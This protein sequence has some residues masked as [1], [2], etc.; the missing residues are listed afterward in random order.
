MN[1]TPLD[2]AREIAQEC[3]SRAPV[4]VLGSGAS[5]PYG[6]PSMADLRKRLLQTTLP[7]ELH[8]ADNAAW[9]TF[10]TKLDEKD[11]E[12]ALNDVSLPNGLAR[13]VA[14]TTWDCIAPRDLCLLRRLVQDRSALVLTRLYRHLFASTHRTVHVVTPNYDR[15]AEYAADAGG[16][17]QY[18]GFSQGLLRSRAQEPALCNRCSRNSPRTVYIWKV[19]GSIDWFYN[20]E[21]SVVALPIADNRPQSLQPVIVTPGNEKYRI[22]HDEPFRSVIQGADGAMGAARGFLCIGYGFNDPHLQPRLADRLRDPSVP[23]VLI[24]KEITAAAKSFLHS[25]SSGRFLAAEAAD[26]GCRVFTS[27]HQ[28]GVVIAGA[29]LWKLDSFLD[30]VT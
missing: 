18:T 19:H 20:A 21:D 3:V 15:L 7:L 23:L 30:L 1:K 2:L 13:L 27:T 28:E 4:L 8:T 17:R 5:V 16:F 6:L 12:S 24:S 9:Q 26:A 25:H 10:L 22:T 14:E 11:L 29:P